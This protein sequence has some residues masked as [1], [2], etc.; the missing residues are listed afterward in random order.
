V[1][2]ML[3][4]HNMVHFFF[5]FF[6]FPLSFVRYLSTLAQLLLY[7]SAHRMIT[8]FAPTGYLPPCLFAGSPARRLG[9]YLKLH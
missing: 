8:N 4:V 7:N 1:F 6:L 9:D 5:F 2:T 3:R